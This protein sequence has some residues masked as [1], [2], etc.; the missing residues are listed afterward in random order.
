[1]QVSAYGT[2]GYCTA[3]MWDPSVSKFN[4]SMGVSCFNA[5]GVSTDTSFTLLYQSRTARF[6]NATKGLAFLYADEPTVA[7]YTPQSIY[8]YNSKGGVNTVIRNS[9]GN[10]TATLPGLT[11]V[12]GDVHVTAANN[13][14]LTTTPMRCKT[15]GWG[16]DGTNTYVNVLCFD[17][18]GAPADE[19]YSLLYSLDEPFAANNTATELAAYEWADNASDTSVYTPAAAYEFNTFRTGRMTSQNTASGQYTANIPGTLSYSNS[20][21]LV[22]GYGSDNSYCNVTTWFPITVACYKQGGNPKN[23]QFDVSFQTSQ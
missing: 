15:A 20:N 19:P 6:G 9:I 14:G 2:N 4:Q 1:V 8:S 10:Y 16:V 13:G 21:V 11:K 12:A 18:N 3:A 22:T 17:V 7:S 5:S 23:S